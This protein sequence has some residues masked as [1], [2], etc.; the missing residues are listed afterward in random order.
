MQ[1]IPDVSPVQQAAAGDNAVSFMQIREH[2]IE[3][4]LPFCAIDGRIKL[5]RAPGEFRQFAPR[6]AAAVGDDLI[7]QS[8]RQRIIADVAQGKKR[9]L[10]PLAEK[11]R[12]QRQHDFF[13]AAAGQ[14]VDNKQY[15]HRYFTKS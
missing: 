7:I 10:F 5:A 12:R 1:A 8:F 9:Y 4:A 6:F 11:V 14:T 2:Q 13:R 15:A 3:A